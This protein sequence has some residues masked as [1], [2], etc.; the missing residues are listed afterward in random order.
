MSHLFVF[1]GAQEGD[2]LAKWE[3][4]SWAKKLAAKKTRANLGDFDRFKVMV[5]RKSKAAAVKAKVAELKK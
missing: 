4:T 3:S 2:I 1:H 5:A